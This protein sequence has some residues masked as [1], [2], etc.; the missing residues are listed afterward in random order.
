MIGT[1]RR[2]AASHVYA[3]SIKNRTEEPVQC[4]VQ[5][6]G[7][8]LEKYSETLTVTI[9]KGGQVYCVGKDY[10]LEGAT[11]QSKK[12]IDKIL[13]KKSSDN[14]EMTLQQPFDGVTG[15]V[16]DWEFH[17]QDKEII[18]QGPPKDE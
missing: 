8:N 11:N 3:A 7:G 6:T 5:Y 16:E 9:D 18:S 1:S 17:I 13:V 12:V 15:P 14:T 4:T 10:Q 2:P